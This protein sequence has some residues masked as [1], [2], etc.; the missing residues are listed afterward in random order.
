M[1]GIFIIPTGIG[2]KIGGHAGDA[3]PYAKLVASVCDKLIIHPNVVNASDI[4]EMTTNMLYVE[5][6]MI[7]RF[8]SGDITLREVKSNRILLVGNPPLSSVTINAANAARHTIG[9]EIEVLELKVPLRMIAKKIENG[10]ASGDVLGWKDLVAQVWGMQFDALA[11]HT[12]IEC[13]RDIALDYYRNGGVNPWGGVESLASRLIATEINKP[14]A[15]APLESVTPEDEELYYIF[16]EVVVPQIA[17]EAISN[18]YLHCVLKGLHKA[19]RIGCGLSV[20][21]VDFLISP[22]NCFGP[23]HRECYNF[24]IPIIQVEENTT[25][26]NKSIDKAITVRNY[27]EAVGCIVAMKE[28]I[29]IREE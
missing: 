19:P 6:S 9:C 12:P 24:D 8:L 23:A 25:C 14:V 3:T 13:D 5:G 7:D 18:S 1:N 22:M 27:L 16:E 26:L 11:I 15:H 21:D 17:A 10:V 29:K 4:N 2:C 20:R 28:G